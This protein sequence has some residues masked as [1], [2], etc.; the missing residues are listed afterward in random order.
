MADRR[1]DRLQGHAQTK[2]DLHTVPPLTMRDLQSGM[3]WLVP[4]A[5]GT[6]LVLAVLAALDALPWD[7]PITEWIADHRTAGLNDFWRFITELGGERVAWVVAGCCVALA[8][9]R[10]RPLAIAILVLA[11][12]RSLWVESLKQIVTRDRPPASLAI[13]HPGGYS[14]P[15][16]HPFAVAASWGFIPL[17]IALYT[18]RRW[19]WWT[20]VFVGLVAR[21]RD[22]RKP[23]VSRC[24]LHDRRHRHPSPR[25]GLRRRRRSS[26]SDTCTAGTTS[27]RLPAA[28]RGAGGR[29]Q[30]TSR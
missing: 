13:T 23:G 14:F 26:S 5:G 1:G 28:F 11:L 8:W 22:R 27:R 30:P 25:S 4:A 21:R 29:A 20:S 6:F 15:S 3:R 9:P 24:P 16:G 17:V 18:R 12:T 19:V 10:C 2:P 7:R